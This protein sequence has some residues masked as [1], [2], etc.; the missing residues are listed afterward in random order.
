MTSEVPTREEFDSIGQLDVP[1][2]ALFGIQTQRAIELYPLEGAQPFSAYTPLLE[3]MLHVK[4]A[5]ARTNIEI[6]ALAA[7]LGDA[8]IRSVDALLCEQRPDAFPVH[9]FHGGGG[10][11]FNMNVNEVLANMANALGFGTAYGVYDPIHPNDHVNLNHSTADCLSTGCHI[12]ALAK[13]DSLSREINGLAT[14]LDQLGERWAPLRKLARTC[15]QDAVDIGFQDYL[16]GV[17]ASLRFH[18]ARAAQAS[19]DLREVSLGG[20]IIGRSSDCDP[21]FFA[22]IIPV[23]NEDLEQTGLAADLRRTD[24]LFAF[25]QGHDRLLALTSTLEQVARV[26]IRFAK[27]LRLMASGPNCGLGE[28]HLPAVQPGSSAIPGKVNPTIPEFMVQCGMVACGRAAAAAMTVD[29]GE[30]DYNPWE[31]VVIVSLLDM[32]AVLRSGVTTLRRNCVQGMLPD[33]ARNT[34]NATSLLPLLI[35]LKQLK[36]YS[37][38]SAVAKEAAGNIAIVR[39]KLAEA[40]GE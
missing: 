13:F 12:A 27:D 1:A 2:D 34:D 10:I 24:N 29:H 25:S 32:I 7:P 39:R 15:L 4:R 31:A 37:Y 26:L 3:A 8:I 5:A 11:S 33:A 38:A 14:D 21:A 6:G 22:R 36:G 20:N 40:E 16:G 17:A 23:L 9:S 18:L 35:R 28:I 19:E 30:M